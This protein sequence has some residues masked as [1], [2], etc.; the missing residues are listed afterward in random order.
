MRSTLTVLW[1]TCLP[2]DSGKSRRQ[3]TNTDGPVI[4]GRVQL[5]INVT[6]LAQRQLGRHHCTYVGS[7][8]KLKKIVKA[9][10][11]FES[12]IYGL[13]MKLLADFYAKAGDSKRHLNLINN[14]L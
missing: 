4:R 5:N 1:C 13:I 7:G 6:Q 9:L 12:K 14:S 10:T 11:L 2:G 3:L 8:F